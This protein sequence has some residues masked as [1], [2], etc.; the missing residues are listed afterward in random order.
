VG[1]GTVEAFVQDLRHEGKM[2]GRLADVQGSAIPVCLGN[3]DLDR[4]YYLD[5]G[6]RIVH[7][8]YMAWGGE[9]LYH[10]TPSVPPATLEYEKQRSLQDVAGLVVHKDVRLEN[11]LWNEE[12]ERVMLIDFERSMVY[13]RKRKLELSHVLDELSPNAKQPRLVT[14]PQERNEK[15]VQHT[16]MNVLVS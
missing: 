4:I 16:S 8:L 11:M 6:V 15:L 10:R 12:N 3:M 9:S 5:V 14:T 13:Q 1:K 7:M 2:Y